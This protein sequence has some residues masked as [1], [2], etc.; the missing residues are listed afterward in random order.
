MWD[1]RNDL[2][3]IKPTLKFETKP[4]MITDIIIYYYR[5]KGL[6]Q[7]ITNKSL[8]LMLWTKVLQQLKKYI[9]FQKHATYFL[10]FEPIPEHEHIT[11]RFNKSHKTLKYIY[12]FF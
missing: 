8:L 3:P 5:L 6:F 7:R 4:V 2:P 12:L 1:V 10:K 9:Y 11:K